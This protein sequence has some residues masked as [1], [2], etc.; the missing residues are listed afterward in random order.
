MKRVSVPS[1]RA[2]M[3]RT[4]L[5]VCAAS[6]NSLKRRTLPPLGSAAAIRAAIER[7]FA[8]MKRGYGFRCVRYLGLV[9]TPA[10]CNSCAP[11]SISS[12]R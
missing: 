6:K 1:T 8:I 12:V 2:T 9:R 7:R 3:R 11:P 10:S 5:Q 4:R